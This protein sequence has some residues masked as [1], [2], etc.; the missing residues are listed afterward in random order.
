[1]GKFLYI[2]RR[3]E[4]ELMHFSEAV[5]TDFRALFTLLEERGALDFPEAR[6]I[7]PDLFELRVRLEGSYRG[8]Y[9]YLDAD[10]IVVLH[11]YQKKTQKAP[12]RN[13]KTAQQRLQR[14]K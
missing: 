14:Y 11:C 8:F 1:M 4:A 6:K 3:A 12:A 13:L 5:E 9:A 7:T 10:A 2:D